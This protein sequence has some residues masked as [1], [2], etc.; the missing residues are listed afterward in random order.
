[1]NEK[2]I[3]AWAYANAYTLIFVATF[4]GITWV[5]IVLANILAD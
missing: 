5:V 1:M 4:F 2:R 3:R